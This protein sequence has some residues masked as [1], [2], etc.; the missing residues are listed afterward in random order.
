LLLTSR[1]VPFKGSKFHNTNQNIQQNN[2]TIF[3]PIA[4]KEKFSLDLILDNKAS[5][6]DI[7]K[8]RPRVDE[9]DDHD[10]IIQKIKKQK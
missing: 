10:F 2:S 1:H 6:K 3:R 8:K 7:S 5:N 9:H 4:L